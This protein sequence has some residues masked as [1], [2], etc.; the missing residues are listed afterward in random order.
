MRR[1]VLAVSGEANLKK[2]E[3]LLVALKAQLT[4]NATHRLDPQRE[5][6]ARDE[7]YLLVKN[8][9][10][11]VQAMME[12]AGRGGELAGA[13]ASS[14]GEILLRA[15]AAHM[16]VEAHQKVQAAASPTAG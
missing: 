1:T 14:Y 5:A 4:A 10:D 13:A 8:A 6:A 11:P 7:L 15:R 9:A 16:P 12:A 2:L 3:N